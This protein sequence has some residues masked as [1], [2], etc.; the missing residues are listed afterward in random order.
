VP[1]TSVP[2]RHLAVLGL[3]FSYTLELDEKLAE[4]A[5]DPNSFANSKL[6]RDSLQDVLKH[7]N[8]SVRKPVQV[9]A[10][11]PMIDH[12]F[13]HELEGISAVAR[14]INIFLLLLYMPSR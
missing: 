5:N 4:A 13:T 8:V 1:F 14:L 7:F 6:N 9:C 12:P 11:E 3:D 10:P 2:E